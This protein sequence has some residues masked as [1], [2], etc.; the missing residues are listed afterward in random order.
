MKI[1][2]SIEKNGEKNGEKKPMEKDM[3]ELMD[4]QKNCAWPEAK[5]RVLDDSQGAHPVG[6][7]SS[8]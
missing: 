8:K 4:E 5:E 2:I 3:E 7:L 6:Q 1:E